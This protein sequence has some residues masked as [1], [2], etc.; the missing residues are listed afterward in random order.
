MTEKVEIEMDLTTPEPTKKELESMREKVAKFEQEVIASHNMRFA[1]ANPD[2]IKIVY[3]M[4]FYNERIPQVLNCL[5]RALPYVDRVV[6]VYDQTVDPDVDLTAISIALI[7]LGFSQQDVSKIEYIYRKWDDHFSRQR[8]AYLGFDPPHINE[9]EWVIVSDPDELFCEEF[10]KDMH[11]IFEDAEKAGINQLGIN[12]HDVTTQLD[13][14]VETVVSDW[15]KQLIFKFEEGVRYV[16][17][18]HETLLPGVTG[19]R[20]GNL[21]KR[22]FYEH[23]KSML[24]IKERGARN[25][26][27]GGGGN[28][29]KDKNPMYVEWHKISDRIGIGADWPRMREYMR[30]GCIDDELKRLIIDHRNDS[31]W[32]YQ[33]ESRDPFIWYKALHPLELEGYESKPEP[34]SKGSPPEVM[35][36]VESQYKEILGR[37]A[38]T[39]GK[40]AYTDA[41]LRGVIPRED[42]PKILMNSEEYK[43]KHTNKEGG[44]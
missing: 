9:G 27:C 34:P 10:L 31:G 19:W 35:S 44:E 14:K 26:F 2:P 37:D 43:Q 16:G 39:K 18:V 13:G 7:D 22:Y 20:P 24:E 30:E 23:I 4:N 6:L 38:D 28:N 41:I 17:C 1:N 15:F 33:N 21:D 12:S 5:E 40:Q 42:I 25:V 11:M 29:V 8:N 36:Y 3:C 32:D